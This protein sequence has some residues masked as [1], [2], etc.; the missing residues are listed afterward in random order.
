MKETT[1]LA[2]KNC[3]K[4]FADM[5]HKIYYLYDLEARGQVF[6]DLPGGPSRDVKFHFNKI[7]PHILF[8]KALRS[9]KQ[10]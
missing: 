3:D 6:I 8:E 4:R 9:D 5:I 1:D 10:V 7:D 2:I